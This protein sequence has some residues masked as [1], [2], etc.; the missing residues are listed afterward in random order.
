MAHFKK[1][2]AALLLFLLSCGAP[3]NKTPLMAAEPEFALVEEHGIKYRDWT[4]KELHKGALTTLSTLLPG[5]RL[6]MVV[7][8]APWCS[9]WHHEM[10]FVN[11]LYEKYKADGFEVIGV[12]EYGSVEDVK[13]CLGPNGAPFTVVVESLD[14][15]ARNRTTH[16]DYRRHTDDNRKWGSPW[17]IFIEPATLVSGGEY[18][19]KNAWV[20]NGELIEA[21]AEAFIKARLGK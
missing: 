11:K 2:N 18:L 19:L 9:N 17:H 1:V 16:Y 8:F 20:A 15:D 21:D 14:R 6:V 13:T 4:F 12:S 10:P 3:M 5:K 7:Y